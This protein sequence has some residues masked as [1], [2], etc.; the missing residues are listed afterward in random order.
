MNT[1]DVIL[2]VFLGFGLIRGFIRGLIVEL[3][4]L[5]AVVIGIYGAI[6]FS[7]YLTQILSQYIE[8]NPSTM[9][10][11]SFA[12]TLILI[13][14]VVMLLAKIL[15]KLVKSMSL[16]FFN[17]IGGGFF[18][19]VKQAV[20]AGA[21]LLFLERTWQTS[22]WIPQEVVENSHLYH[23]VKNV[24]QLVYANVFK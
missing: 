14:L 9:K 24:G 3:G 11:L 22:E 5:L 1:I 12:L 2:L 6:H 17:R 18:G 7:F 10:A 21:V 19:L 4:T 13:M 16:G 8:L 15:T 23:I 20:I